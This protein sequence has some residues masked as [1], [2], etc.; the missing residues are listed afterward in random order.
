MGKTVRR[1]VIQYLM[2]A[3][4]LGFGW[5]SCAR[6]MPIIIMI[7]FSVARSF[8][9]QLLSDLWVVIIVGRVRVIICRF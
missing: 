3:L 7:I 4:G 2:S 1:V 5:G 8:L 6:E 9:E